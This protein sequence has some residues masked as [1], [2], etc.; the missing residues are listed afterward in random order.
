MF[1]W[2]PGCKTRGF[3]GP[4]P[5]R[6]HGRDSSLSTGVPLNPDVAMPAR[7]QRLAQAVLGWEPILERLREILRESMND[8]GAAGGDAEE[9]QTAAHTIQS[10]A[11][12]F[13]REEHLIPRLEEVIGKGG[14][15]TNEARE[16]VELLER[17]VGLDPSSAILPTDV[18]SR[19]ARPGASL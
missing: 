6:G 8:T 9:I 17:I 19:L 7:F 16:V 15:E 18:I 1:F 2:P 4:S 14:P 5:L 13:L 10:E 12:H 11:D 3:Y